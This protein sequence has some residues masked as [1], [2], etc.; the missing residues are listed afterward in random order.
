MRSRDNRLLSRMGT[1]LQSGY[2]IDSWYWQ[3]DI[4]RLVLGV[5]NVLHSLAITMINRVNWAQWGSDYE[6]GWQGA[7][8]KLS[9][10]CWSVA[11]YLVIMPNFYAC[12]SLQIKSGWHRI[13]N[14]DSACLWFNN[15][16]YHLVCRMSDPKWCM[17]LFVRAISCL[18][19]TDVQPVAGKMPVASREAASMRKQ[20][21]RLDHTLLNSSVLSS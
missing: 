8:G 1:P 7:A 18:S 20:C 10:C 12:K 15:R 3:V 21:K 2:I 11:L 17:E 4:L 5:C 6:A 16:G 13:S 9:E 14:E 19:V